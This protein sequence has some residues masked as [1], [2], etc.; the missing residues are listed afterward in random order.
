MAI[1]SRWRVKFSLYLMI[2]KI[3]GISQRHFEFRGGGNGSHKRS[4]SSEFLDVQMHWM[5]VY[6]VLAEEFTLWLRRLSWMP[7]HKPEEEFFTWKPLL[8]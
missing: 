7:S 1:Y 8:P 2:G 6:F 3:L 4:S 5:R